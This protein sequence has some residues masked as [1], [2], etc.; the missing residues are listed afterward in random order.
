MPQYFEYHHLRIL[1][2]GMMCMMLLYAL[3]NFLQQK[4][5]I[6]YQYALY[7]FCLLINFQ[8][9]DFGHRQS[10]FD[11]DAYFCEIFSQSI[12]FILYI[13]FATRLMDFKNNDPLSYRITRYMLAMVWLSAFVSVTGYF[14][15]LPDKF[16][17]TFNIVNRFSLGGCALYVVPRILRLRNVV[18]AYFI[19]G[20]FFFV[21]GSLIALSVNV[22][23]ELFARMEEKPF[24]FPLIYMQIG[25]VIENFCFLLGLS[26]LN[27]QHELEKLSF[28]QQLVEQL[29][30]NH[31]QQIKLYNVRDDIARD[32]HDDMGSYL[33]S[34]SVLSRN[35][36]KTGDKDPLMA[37]MQLQKIG[38]IARQVMDG[39]NDIVWSVNPSND[40]MQEIVGKM[41]SIALDL[42]ETMDCKVCFNI[43]DHVFEHCLIMEKR[44]D[45]LMIYKEILTNAAR[46]SR[47]DLIRIELRFEDNQLELKITDNGIGFDPLHPPT[48]KGGNGLKNLRIRAERL[49]GRLKVVSKVNQ[50]TAIQLCICPQDMP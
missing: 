46:Y 13:G 33:S 30:E 4:K 9:N 45:F 26:V 25:V 8:A 48:S 47:A 41:R 40:S 29:R 22:W 2:D 49:E 10:K 11:D 35:V 5:K 15:N 6:Y 3:F 43:S 36:E 14:L 17:T 32:L 38:E 21:A 1:F 7:I 27:H 34:I 19:A 20:S 28:Q 50:G 31:Q 39:L 42:F 12:A 18:I 23:P 37:R 24:T 44:R 16:L